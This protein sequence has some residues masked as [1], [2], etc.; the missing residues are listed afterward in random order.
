MAPLLSYQPLKALATIAFLALS[1]PYLVVL[2]VLHLLGVRRI[3]PSYSLRT[4]ISVD[5]LWLFYQYATLIHLEPSYASAAKFKDRYVLVQPAAPDL[6]Q[7]VLQ[8]EH[9]KPASVPAIWC[10]S[11]PPHDLAGHDGTVV[12]HFQG[13]AFVTALDPDS[14]APAVSRAYRT[15]LGA[16]TLFAQYRL[17]R[18]EDT[19]FP[20]A[21]QDAVTC[22]RHVLDAGV[23]PQKVVVAGDSAGG[24]V[25]VGLLRY[26][27][28]TGALP[29][30]RGV[31]L[32]SPWVDVSAPAVKASRRKENRRSDFLP[33]GLMAWGLAAVQPARRTLEVERYLRPLSHPF[34]T[35]TPIFVNAGTAELLHDE[36]SRFAAR[37]ED[38][39]GNR[40]CY[41]ETEGAPHDLVLAGMAMGFERQALEAIGRAADFFGL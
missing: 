7:D 26:V 27:E 12:I 22:Y 35:S 14:T 31:M 10:P 11:A 5:A 2:S 21:L 4:A 41:V 28:S 30:P 8:S 20:A 16:F 3:H 40:V 32:W 15:K 34:A 25:A 39:P 6:Y 38:V 9:V 1:P 13:G 33:H 17:S 36:D 18:G 23:P 29:P 24:T 37:M 19:R